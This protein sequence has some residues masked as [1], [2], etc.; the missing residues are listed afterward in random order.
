VA[1]YSV[2]YVAPRMSFSYTPQIPADERNSAEA[3]GSAHEDGSVAHQIELFRDTGRRQQVQHFLRRL[4]GITVI[5]IAGVTLGLAQNSQPAQSGQAA[6]AAPAAPAEKK[7]QYKDQQEYT[8]YDSVTKE[9]DP[10]K[11]L[12]LLST[13]KDKYSDSDFKL[14][15]A[16]LFLDTYQKLGQ[17]AKMIDASKDVLAIDPKELHALYWITLL[18]PQLSLNSQDGLD[19]GEKAA[20]G[21]LNAEAP[22]GTKPE[23]W[24][25]AKKTTDAIAYK[26]LG[27]IAWQRKTYDVAEKNFVQSLQMEPA[28]GEVDY[29]LGTVIYL[30]KKPERISEAMFYFA[31]AAAYDGPGAMTPQQRKQ[32]DDFLSKV[33]SQLHGDTTGLA[34]LKAMA[35]TST[36]PPADFKIKTAAEIAAEKEE[37]LKKTN[38]ELALWLNLKGQLLSPEGQTY[39]DSSMKGAAVP[40][41]KGWL[42]SAKPPVKSKELLVSMEGK[43]QAPNVTLKLVGSDGATA[44]PLTGKPVVGVEIQFEGIGDSLTKDPALMVTFDVEKGKVCTITPDGCTTLKEEKVAPVHHTVHKKS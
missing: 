28:S 8:L 37:E 3:T 18:T 2:E 33:Y 14:A 34:E 21:L 22:A 7:P 44:A 20:N 16:L 29:W 27:W 42:V 5:A 10:N 35:K 43:D 13:W 36:T 40:K 25:K 39:F 19:T 32:A 23:D 9:A 17:Y 12:A 1:A 41:L 6:P 26:T 15:R 30:Q 24:T 11:K 31:R 38:P 4:T